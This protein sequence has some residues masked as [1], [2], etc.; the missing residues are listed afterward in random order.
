MN[1][2]EREELPEPALSFPTGVWLRNGSQILAGDYYTADQMRTYRLCRAGRGD[3]WTEARLRE[4][5]KRRGWYVREGTSVPTADGEWRHP[6]EMTVSSRDL[7]ELLRRL[8]PQAG[9]SDG[10]V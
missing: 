7:I 3:F 6:F 10:T 1:T 5:A 4:E 2:H 9:G 8:S